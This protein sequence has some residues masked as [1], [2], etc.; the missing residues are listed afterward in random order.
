MLRN[1]IYIGGSVLVFFTGLVVYGI[2]L[3]TT[4]IPLNEALRNKGIKTF[5][6]IKLVVYRDEY[7]LELFSDS[8]LIKSYKVV[9]GR[10]NKT[11]KKSK[12]DFITPAGKYFICSIDTGV[13]YHKF[14]HLNYPSEKDASDAL[15]KGIIS[16][17]EFSE[18]LTASENGD[19]PPGNT[20]LGSEIGIHGIGEFDFIFRNLPFAFNWTNGSIAM[21][22]EDIDELYNIIK[23]GAPV[24]IR[25]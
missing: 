15:R 9:F 12:N 3:N 8:I 20:A 17:E 14:F 10:N 11:Q 6:E 1:I 24:I 4:Q 25:K 18:V 13:I 7:L 2:I 22:N 21:S 5:G 23:V 19:C 16:R